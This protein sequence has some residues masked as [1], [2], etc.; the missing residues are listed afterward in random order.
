MA[1]LNNDLRFFQFMSIA[2]S[3]RK[4]YEQGWNCYLSFCTQ[5]GHPAFP[6]TERTLCLFVTSL[7]K[8][9][10]Y[11]SIRTYLAAVRFHNIEL[12][13]S[14]NFDHLQQLHMLMRGIKR[15]KGK[16]VRPKRNP[17]TP[18]LMKVLK[19]RLREASF[20]E[21]DKLMMWAAFTTAFF[22]FLRSSEFCSPTRFT[23]HPESTLLAKDVLLSEN[24]AILSIKVSKADPFRN[25]SQVRL[26]A[27][28]SSV[29]PFRALRKYLY[30]GHNP[31][32]PLF[33]FSDGTFLTRQIISST[34]KSLL[35]PVLGDTKG[36]SSHSFRIGAAT[37]AAA[38]DIPDWLIKALGR[39][40]SNCFEQYIRTPNNLVHSVPSKLSATR[41]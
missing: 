26:A 14:I 38:A 15:V 12:G 34:M 41:F 10:G 28:S 9:L 3:S 6:V 36:Y 13:F 35:Q 32:L 30:F 4:T 8:F 33:K 2:T 29:C 20:I 23:F 16:S 22:G 5:I 19:S 25:G 11:A 1:S 17:I 24:I 21:Q 18:E 31:S 7:A 40:S 37:T 27:S 39:W